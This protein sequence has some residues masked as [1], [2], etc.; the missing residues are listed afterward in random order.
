MDNQMVKEHNIMQ[1]VQNMKEILKKEDVME[2]GYFI[3]QMA[4]NMMV[5]IITKIFI[6]NHKLHL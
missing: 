3:T 5:I 6:I 4:K 1:M 2:K